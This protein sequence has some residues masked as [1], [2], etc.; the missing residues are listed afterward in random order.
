MNKKT[1]IILLLGIIG[2]S[3][4][5]AAQVSESRARAIASEFFNVN[6]PV[7]PATMKAHG[8][9]AAYYV[10]NNPEQPGWV[11]I[12]GDDRARQILAYGDED[13]FDAA[14]VPDCIQDWL[15]TYAMQIAGIDGATTH[16]SAN[17]A[18]TQSLAASSKSRIAP[19]LTSNWAQGLPF[20]QQC[21]T[22][23]EG[24]SNYCP[25]G[26]VA[27]AMAQILYYYKSGTQC[28]AIPGYTSQ[29]LNRYM[30]ALPATIFNYSVMNDWYENE[31][32]NSTSAQETAKLVRYCAQSVQMNFGVNSSS[33][34]SQRN[35]FVYYFGFDKDAMQHSRTDYNANDWENMVYTELA[36]GRPVY[37]SARKESGGH[38]FIC[39]GYENGLFHINW[40][41]R[42]HQNG[43][44]ALNALS[45]GNAGGTGAASGEEGYTINV[46][47][48]TGLQ[49]STG[50]TPVPT[51]TVLQY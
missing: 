4:S 20:N 12:A 2:A 30:P 42:S 13:Y 41:W 8:N 35:A 26:C 6:M 27:I 38:A 23:T 43:Y 5:F 46:Q 50:S 40:G 51:A 32:N 1:A 48:M 44:F 49:P 37:I 21:A 31:V 10:F 16:H 25:A 11:I 19:M 33:A 17:Y 45:D 24:G 36:G 9:N 18:P 3:N 29:R 14:D 39:D 47:I 7:K 28:V 34:T 15:D 22:T